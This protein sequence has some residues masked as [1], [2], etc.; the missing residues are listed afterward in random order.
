MKKA[1]KKDKR[2]EYEDERSGLG[3]KVKSETANKKFSTEEITSDMTKK[4][5]SLISYDNKAPLSILR[6]ST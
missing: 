2:K 3:K 1:K 4:G 6:A 5:N